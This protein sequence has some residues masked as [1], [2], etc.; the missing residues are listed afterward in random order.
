MIVLSP[1]AVGFG[2]NIQAANHVV[3]FTRTWNPAKEDQATDRAYRIGQTKSVRITTLEADHELDSRINVL[4]AHKQDMID[5][6]VEAARV[7]QGERV[8]L[9]VVAEVERVALPVVAEVERVALP[10]L[11]DFSDLPFAL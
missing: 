8:A 4:L 1:L 3:H 11:P 2:V 10:V 6:V 9:P 7:K 5:G